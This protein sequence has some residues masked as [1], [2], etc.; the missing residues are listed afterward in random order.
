MA[1]VTPSSQS[2]SSTPP[3]SGARQYSWML[4]GAIGGT[5]LSALFFTGAGHLQ[6]ALV[7]HARQT[8][9][10]ATTPAHALGATDATDA[11]LTNIS[12][13][14]K[15]LPGVSGEMFTPA[16][17]LNDTPALAPSQGEISLAA[18]DRL[19][20]GNCIRLTTKTGQT[21]AFRIVGARPADGANG[22]NALP[23]I[24]LAVTTCE[25]GN[26]PLIT[27]AIIESSEQPVKD[28]VAQ[29]TL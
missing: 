10:I 24:D 16:I 25:G 13:S 11:L 19:S 28:A 2:T 23:E 17:A 29:H 5:V 15:R 3:V 4:L 26:E 7:D 8:A 12:T 22:N 6:S 21:L 27:K 14:T 1:R 9:A 20:S 18:W